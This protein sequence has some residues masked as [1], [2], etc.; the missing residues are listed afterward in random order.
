MEELNAGGGADEGR[1]GGAALVEDERRFV[2]M[3]RSRCFMTREHE[4]FDYR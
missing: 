1:R 4:I 2:D 3:S